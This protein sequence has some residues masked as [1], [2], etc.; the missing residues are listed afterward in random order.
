MAIRNGVSTVPAAALG[1]GGGTASVNNFENRGRSE[2]AGR[3]EAG[4]IG[5]RGCGVAS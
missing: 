1:N 5:G 3:D 4:V 2:S